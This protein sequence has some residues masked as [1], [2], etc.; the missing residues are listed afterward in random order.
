[1][2]ANPQIYIL[3]GEASGD[4]HAANLVAAWKQIAP[5]IQFRAW[6][7]DRL[8]AE[9][10]QIDKHI[11][12]LSFM[13]FWEVF[14]NLPVIRK[15]FKTI[16]AQLLTEK[17]DLL[18]LVDYP[19]FNLRMAK[20]AKDH[21]IKV[22]YYISPT[23]W[24][25]KQ[26]RVF[27]IQKNVNQLYCILPFEPAF[28]AKFGLK[29]AYFGHPL[30]DEIETYRKKAPVDVQ[31]DKPILALLP[32][33][34][35]Q[36]LQRLLPVMLAAAKNFESTHRIHLVCAPHISLAYYESFGLPASI[37][38][39]QGHTY[40]TLSIADMAL[41]TSGTATLETALFE[42][43]QVVC[44]KSSAFSV[45]LARKLVNI[46][47][48]SLVNL[49]LDRKVVTELIQEECTPERM[50]DEL[51]LIAP[52]SGGRAAQLTAYKAL[53]SQLYLEESPSQLVAKSMNSYL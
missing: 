33:S 26:K 4:L 15:Q 39:V 1:M 47:F 8:K 20:W 10:V 23:V 22:L 3:S 52:N 12:E 24:A 35:K 46:K 9:G 48:I 2:K 11:R 21:G 37:N 34:R 28:Y 44:Y 29:V 41:V 27:D 7:G 38:C 5:Q 13:G 17:P 36:E 16:Q 30:L 50:R 18:V 14:K 19:G 6:G 49:I 40:D 42:V 51:L 43:P 32:G 53:K 31:Y 25:W 45:W